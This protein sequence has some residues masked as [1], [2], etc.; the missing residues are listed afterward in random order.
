MTEQAG[1]PAE[2]WATRAAAGCLVAVIL[3]WGVHAAIDGWYPIGDNALLTLRA[4]DVLTAHHPWLGTWTSA[5]LSVGTPINNPGPLQF[6]VLAP[7]AKVDAAG[8]MAVGVAVVNALV[9][10]LIAIFARRAG[11]DRLAATAM[12]AAG[13][14]TFAMGSELLFD[15]WQPHHLLLPFLGLIVLAVALASGDV[16][17]LPWGVAVVSFLVQTHLSYAVLAPGILA[18]GLAWLAL[19]LRSRPGDGM[20][21]RVRR[22]R[23]RRAVVVSVVVGLACWAQPLWEQVARDGNLL[24]VAGNAGGGDEVVGVGSGVRLAGSVIGDPSGWSRSSF[25]GTFAHD[26]LGEQVAPSGPPNAGVRSLPAAAASVLGVGILLGAS[27]WVGRRRGHREASGV[28]VVV[29]VA[30]VLAVATCASLPASEVLGI[31]AHQLRWLWPIAIAAAV[32]PWAALLPR[33]PSSTLG[34]AALAVVAAAATLVPANA[35]AGPSAD[36]AARPAVS[37]FA[38]ALD[39]V[40][41]DEVVYFDGETVPFAEPFSGPLLLELQRRGISFEVD[42]GPLS[43]QVGPARRG[44]REATRQLWLLVGDPGADPPPGGEVLGRID[45]LDAAERARADALAEQ[46][47]RSW[48]GAEVRLNER[49]RAAWRAGAL[50][51]PDRPGWG[52][53]VEL[54]VDRSGLARLVDEDWVDL[55]SL[56]DGAEEWSRLEHRARRYSVVVALGPIQP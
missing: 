38:D 28:A 27:A 11:G 3:W 14:L 31:A 37:A 4:R 39:A 7:F 40:P 41:R 35:G 26:F 24:E 19:G 1:G 56:P 15:P 16:W 13:A 55:D 44:P 23:L 36:V 21:A 32:L 50:T 30:V 22:D 51:E 46:L 25:A 45:G 53:D 9:V 12:V 48:G 6:D 17:A 54:L 8:G 33:R 47:R 43:Y 34:L 42:P 5:S 52:S 49:G 10:V 29:G 18:T 20:D 2:R